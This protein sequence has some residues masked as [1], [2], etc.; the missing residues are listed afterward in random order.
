MRSDDANDILSRAVVYLTV[1]TRVIS[2]ASRSSDGYL[3]PCRRFDYLPSNDEARFD[4]G[5]YMIFF[6]FTLTVSIGNSLTP[7]SEGGANGSISG[8]KSQLLEVTL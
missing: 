5:V 2:L 7:T 4:S 6:F 1:H 8:P 3:P